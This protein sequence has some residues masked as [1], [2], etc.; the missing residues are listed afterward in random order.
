MDSRGFI[1]SEKAWEG[2]GELLTSGRQRQMGEGG[3]IKVKQEAERIA[4]MS[5][6]YNV[7]SSNPKEKN[8]FLQLGPTS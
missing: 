5:N 7:Q 4:G 2:M 8:Y 1:S 6:S 3:H